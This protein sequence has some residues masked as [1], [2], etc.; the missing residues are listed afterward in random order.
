MI[1]EAA[2]QPQ[3]TF[4]FGDAEVIH[5]HEIGH[6]INPGLDQFGFLSD[7][8]AVLLFD[9]DLFFHDVAPLSG[10][11]VQGRASEF[12]SFISYSAAPSIPS[13]KCHPPKPILITDKEDQVLSNV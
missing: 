9:D 4:L 10:T 5:R 13:G 12:A 2:F 1:V 6:G 8:G 11:A 3:R 7:G